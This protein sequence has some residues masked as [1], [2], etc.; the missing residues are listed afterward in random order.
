MAKVTPFLTCTLYHISAR[1]DGGLVPRDD[2]TWGGGLRDG[3][4]CLNS[5]LAGMHCLL[6]PLH[7]MMSLCLHV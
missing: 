3:S 4:H 1:V 7:V 5:V 2:R 6:E